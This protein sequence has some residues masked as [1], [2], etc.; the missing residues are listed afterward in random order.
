MA[1]IEETIE[2]TCPNCLDAHLVVVKALYN[3]APEV[4]T[5]QL[6][7]GGKVIVDA[8]DYD[9]LSH[10]YWYKADVGYARNS[11]KMFMHTMIMGLA[12]KRY[13]VDHINGDK[14]DNRRRNLR[15]VTASV[16]SINN[17][18]KPHGASGYKGVY[19]D[20]RTKRWVAQFRHKHLGTFSDEEVA[21]TA[22]QTARHSYLQNREL[23]AEAKRLYD[24]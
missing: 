13:V 7:N 19:Q 3:N 8:V 16:N 15:V 2:C 21:A 17:R 1:V 24:V 14:L 9:F 23:Y 22:Y 18:R 11:Y 4:A 12:D 5:I 6:S 20:A 10:Y